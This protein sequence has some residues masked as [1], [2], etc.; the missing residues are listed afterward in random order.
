MPTGVSRAHFRALG[1]PP[2]NLQRGPDPTSLALGPRR[3]RRSP[4]KTV[5]RQFAMMAVLCAGDRKDPWHPVQSSPPSPACPIPYF[6]VDFHPSLH[7]IWFAGGFISRCPFLYLLSV[8]YLPP[9]HPIHLH[10]PTP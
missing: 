5:G 10:L 1:G 7:A 8:R 6:E 2:A 4:C 9:Y 3:E